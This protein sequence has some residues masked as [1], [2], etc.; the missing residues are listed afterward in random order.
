[1]SRNRGT[2]DCA[3]GL[4][5]FQTERFFPPGDSSLLT[6]ERYLAEIGWAL[7]PYIGPKKVIGSEADGY[8]YR[9][10]LV[11]DRYRYLDPAEAGQEHRGSSFGGGPHGRFT[12]P[13][14]ACRYL[15]V[16]P[17][18]RYRYRRLD[19]VFCR[20]LYVGWYRQD[21]V[22]VLAVGVYD[23]AELPGFRLYDTSH[24]HSFND[25]PGKEDLRNVREWTPEKLAALAKRWNEEER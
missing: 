24:W 1:M 4:W 6:P 20:R 19:C 10:D 13:E 18:D 14:L 23:W 11:G 2:I 12:E 9:A 17:E 15:D 21:P 25:E 3:C 22:D 5:A 7:C 8:G 16:P